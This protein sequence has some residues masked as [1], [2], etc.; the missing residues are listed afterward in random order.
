MP[1]APFYFSIPLF[2]EIIYIPGKKT[3]HY[4]NN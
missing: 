1:V 4:E 2:S 3:K